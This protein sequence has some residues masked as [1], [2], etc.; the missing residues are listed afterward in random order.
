M[1][2]V[3]FVKKDIPLNTQI[4]DKN[5]DEF[6]EIKPI[7]AP[8]PARAVKEMKALKDKYVIAQQT[9]E[10]PLM[11]NALSDTELPPDVRI[12]EK[13]VEKIV[14]VPAK[15]EKVVD[16]KT[17]LLQHTLTIIGP[18]GAKNDYTFEG[19]KKGKLRQVDQP[20]KS[21]DKIDV[22]PLETNE[23]LPKPAPIKPMTGNRAL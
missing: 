7:L 18:T 2:K 11:E 4:T 1:E 19:D 15:T 20:S 14:E 8:A 23:E 12:V 10:F 3:V 21:D 17:P 9:A 6:F 22:K 13:I 16:P 5:I